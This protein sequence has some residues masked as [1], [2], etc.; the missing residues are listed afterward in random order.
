MKRK[1][2][3]TAEIVLTLVTFGILLMYG[4]W[5]GLSL[6]EYSLNLIFFVVDIVV[7][8]AVTSTL[9]FTAIVSIT[10]LI[11][12]RGALKKKEDWRSTYQ[13]E[14]AKAIIPVYRDAEV[15]H[16]SIETLAESNYSNLETLI[17][18][19]PDDKETKTRAEDLE[20]EY[21]NVEAMENGNPG[22]KA[23]AINYAVENTEAEHYAIFDS[24]EEI[25]P[26]FIPA[27]VSY[28]EEDG[29]D[30]FQGR[31]IPKPEDLVEAF[32]YCERALFHTTY[33]LARYTGFKSPRSSSTVMKKSSWKEVGGYSDMLTEDLDFPHK[34]YRAG[35]KVKQA[36]NYTNMMEAPHSFKDF[37]GQRKRWNIGQVQIAHKTLSGGFGNNL[38]IRGA[39]STFRSVFGII[40]AILLLPLVAKFIL[41]LVF[42]F[43]AVY[44]PPL[45]ALTLIPAF[46]SLIDSRDQEVQPLYFK[47]LLSPFVIIVSGALMLKSVFE[48]VFSWNGE[49]YHVDK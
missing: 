18:Y 39:I 37:W 41:L 34:C 36:Y 26:D 11:M 22:S 6:K 24:D 28:L 43:E 13:G 5:T 10:G 46:L 31:R 23:K 15:M 45:L 30:I 17:V 27:A 42:G 19:E 12:L 21:E 48:Y 49:W 4:G 9:Y 20:R 47:A 33:S 40:L 38:S 35:L 2:I 29:Y 1:I 3:R 7:A 32:C 8:D 44:I 16:Q 25:S 14:K